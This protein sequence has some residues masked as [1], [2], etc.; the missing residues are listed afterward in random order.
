MEARRRVTAVE[1]SQIVTAVAGTGGV[2]H[3]FNYFV[4]FS[5]EN[6]ASRARRL[7]R[8]HGLGRLHP[9]PRGQEAHL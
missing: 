1:R 5:H 2:S 6:L 4:N 8:L 3:Y 9:R 7:G